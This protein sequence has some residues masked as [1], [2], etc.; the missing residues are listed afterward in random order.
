MLDY[1][2]V[3]FLTLC[4]QMNYRRTAEKLNMTQPGV[5]QHIHA[6]EKEFDCKLFVYDGKT[7]FLTEQGRLYREYLQKVRYDEKWL[8]ERLL[9]KKIPNLH[10]GATKSI[11]DYMISKPLAALLNSGEFTLDLTVDNTQVLL[12]QIKNGVID[13]AM[14][15]GDFDKNEFGF[16]KMWSEPFVGM[17]SADHAF[18][19][20]SVELKDVFAEHLLLREEGSGTRAIF[21]QQL[22]Y[23]GES[24][25]SF[26]KVNYIS[27]FHVMKEILA[28]GNTVSFGYLSV[29]SGD[30]RLEAFSV[31]NFIP[32]HDLYYVYQKNSHAQQLLNRYIEI[33]KL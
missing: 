28:G 9:E 13:F 30:N 8:R 22:A 14:I 20:K 16:R 15:E 27:S 31:R 11:G 21:E 6:L 5:T 33:S 18:A 29:I 25:D 23:H 17:C 2:T 1:K 4:E 32:T 10:I 3:T 19:G 12:E 7:L 24:T 26:L